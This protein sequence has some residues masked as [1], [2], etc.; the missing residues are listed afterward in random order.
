MARL[1]KDLP[2]WRISDSPRSRD[3]GW[4]SQLQQLLDHISQHGSLPVWAGSRS[5]EE[6]SLGNWLRSQ[7]Q[8]LQAGRLQ[9]E[10][11]D[12]FD[13]IAPS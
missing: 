7:R 6:N 12:K 9:R 13:A 10:R 5:K 1:D 3:E 4:N 11:G 8:S 2:G